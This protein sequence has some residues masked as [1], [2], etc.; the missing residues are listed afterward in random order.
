MFLQAV[1]YLY[2]L[3]VCQCVFCY[4]T[5]MDK[6]GSVYIAYWM[7]ISIINKGGIYKFVIM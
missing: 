4:R 6:L 1:D 3:H 5:C 2:T 7:V